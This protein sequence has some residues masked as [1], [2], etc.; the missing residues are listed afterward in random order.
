MTDGSTA[1]TIRRMSTRDSGAIMKI[2]F[3]ICRY[4][5]QEE[6][7]VRSGGISKSTTRFDAILL[8]GDAGSIQSQ[9]VADPLL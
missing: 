9:R 7:D 4:G 8:L 1:S 6:N 3:I 5:D 2:V